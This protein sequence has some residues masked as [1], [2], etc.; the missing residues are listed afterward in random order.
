MNDRTFD[1]AFWAS[2]IDVLTTL[3][4]PTYANDYMGGTRGWW[5]DQQQKHTLH[6]VVDMILQKH[7]CAPSNRHLLLLE[8]PHIA[9]TDTTRLAYTRDENKG[10]AE[11]QTLTSIGKYVARHWPH[12]AD[13]VRAQWCATY[14]P[15]TFELRDTPEGIISGIELGPQSCMKSC[16]KPMHGT[17]PFDSDDHQTMVAWLRDDTQEEPPWESHPYICYSPNHDWRM[18][19][20]INKGQ[21]DIVMGRALTNG[22]VF[23]R[24]YMRGATDAAR[25]QTDDMLDA[26]LINTHGMSKVRQWPEGLKMRKVDYP[27]PNAHRQSEFLAPYIDGDRQTVRIVDSS[28]LCIED[29]D[30][31]RGSVFYE[32]DHT[33]G[34]AC[35]IESENYRE[36]EDC[37]A[38]MGEDD[39]N[40]VGIDEE[41]CVCE[42]CIS[43]YTHAEY[44]NY[45]RTAYFPDNDT[46]CVNGNSYCTDDLPDEVVCCEDGEYRM[47]DDCV[48]IDGDFY[49]EEECVYCEDIEEYILIVD[50]WQCTAT[51]KW[52]S[53][54]SESVWI[55]GCIYHPDNAPNEAQ[56]TLFE[57]T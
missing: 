45:G 51:N 34:T 22:K 2:A 31:D 39:G 3:N 35:E 40:Y 8:W 44:G 19:V 10:R 15:D 4:R 52:Y 28:T 56:Q 27:N 21:P 32:C 23:V 37:G 54:D 38:G 41:R 9:T 29:A 6:P 42:S 5:I 18:A 16:V 30:N 12:V 14:S 46:V 57:T 48:E 50:G 13:H 26:W 24:S 49:P 43:D 36:C 7:R 20:R 47:Q 11:Q 1:P 33:D 17:I 25:S 53:D 55:D